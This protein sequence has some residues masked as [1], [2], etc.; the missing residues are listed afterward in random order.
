MEET[1]G[2]DIKVEESSGN[3]DHAISFLVTSLPAK[4]SLAG[5]SLLAL[6]QASVYAA[7]CIPDYGFEEYGNPQTGQPY[8]RVAM[9]TT[10]VSNPRKEGPYIAV[11]DFS[12]TG[13]PVHWRY[14]SLNFSWTQPKNF[15]NGRTADDHI[16]YR[17]Q[18]DDGGYYVGPANAIEKVIPKTTLSA[19][20]VNT[21]TSGIV[22]TLYAVFSDGSD[23]QFGSVSLA[24]G[25]NVESVRGNLNVQFSTA[26][27]N[28]PEPMPAELPYDRGTWSNN[29]YWNPWVERI[30]YE[31]NNPPAPNPPPAPPT[32]APDPPPTVPPTP[33]PPTPAPD[34]PPTAPPTPAD[35]T[36]VSSVPYYPVLFGEQ[37]DFD[38]LQVGTSST[39]LFN[40]SNIGRD[41]LEIKSIES[42]SSDL[43]V[44]PGVDLEN[45]QSWIYIFHDQMK[46]F[47]LTLTGNT[48]GTVIDTLYITS[49]NND[50]KNSTYVI[51][52][53]GEVVEGFPVLEVTPTQLAFDEINRGQEIKQSFVVKNGGLSPLEVSDFAVDIEGVE[54]TATFVP[55]EVTVSPGDSVGVSVSLVFMGVL[56][57]QG[58]GTIYIV[59]NKQDI[60]RYALSFSFDVSL[61]SRADFNADG[62]VDVQ[63]FLVFVKAFGSVQEKDA[64]YDLD[65]DGI[66]GVGDFLLF[67]SVF[68]TGLE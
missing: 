51:S 7:K 36:V 42:S 38:T 56:P 5:L 2:E 8:F 49:N 25:Q 9:G 64:Q 45:R 62:V 66:V 6:M 30:L 35:T 40:L 12:E 31:R 17:I 58:V 26:P 60:E 61:R 16:G 21:A 44:E 10:Y 11:T 18:R 67:A 68:G 52:V 14:K 28:H 53:T 37:V 20:R 59:S 65:N 13:P 39:R 63:D 22:Y 57:K 19:N 4:I 47:Q 23:E 1:M 27:S 50:Q 34:P 41:L 3:Y 48:V 29:P 15:S 54:Y 46:V 32:P 43:V 55:S 33:A 24:C